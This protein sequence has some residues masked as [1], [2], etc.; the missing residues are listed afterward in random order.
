MSERPEFTTRAAKRVFPTII[1]VLLLCYLLWGWSGPV[2]AVGLFY[3]TWIVFVAVMGLKWT[4]DRHQS[5][6]RPIPTPFKL[7]AWPVV[8][9]FGLMDVAFNVVYGTL[10]FHEL[11]KEWL[12]TERVSRWN[13]LNTWQG[14]LAKWL[15]WAWLDPADPDG[16]HCS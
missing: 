5:R 15:C 11:P 8:F 3:A 2:L 4:R 12:F 7:F 9:V 10:F 6:G 1:V 16:V 14:D 13:D